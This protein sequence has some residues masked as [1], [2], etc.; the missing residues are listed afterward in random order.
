MEKKS[1]LS[2]KLVVAIAALIVVVIGAT[3]VIVYMLTHNG[4]TAGDGMTIGYATNASVFLDQDSL[5]AAMDEAMKNSDTIGLWYKNNAFSTDGVNFD[6]F[7]GNSASNLHDIFLTIFADGEMKDQIFLSQLLR[8]GT[9]F[10]QIRLS[11]PLDVGT[12]TV[13]VVVTTVDV[14][15]NGQQVIKGQ[16]SHTMDFHVTK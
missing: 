10:E 4:E 16:V 1:V 8:P 15:E 3:G 13:Y 14:D 7:I 6:C 5:Q 9:G 2:T 11:H 12:T